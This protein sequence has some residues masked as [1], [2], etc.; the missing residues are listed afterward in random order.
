MIK[1]NIPDKYLALES[2]TEYFEFPVPTTWPPR[3]A[4]PLSMKMGEGGE[5]VSLIGLLNFFSSY[6][7]EN[8]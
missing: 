2:T 6:S 3:Y 5:R 1:Y 4:L 8:L 7:S